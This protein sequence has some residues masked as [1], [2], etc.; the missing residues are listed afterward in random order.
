MRTH[1]K[2]KTKSDCAVCYSEHDDEIHEA[3]LRIH[4][5][6]LDQVT[7]NFEDRAVPA[8]EMQPE[9]IAS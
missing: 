5:W 1:A 4:S 2:K 7:R 6:L 3:T 9:E 8:P